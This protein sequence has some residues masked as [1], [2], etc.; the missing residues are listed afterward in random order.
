[1]TV[2]H[3]NWWKCWNCTDTFQLQAASRTECALAP[4]YSVHASTFILG[5]RPHTNRTIVHPDKDFTVHQPLKQ[6]R[7]RKW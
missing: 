2:G 4:V 1:M 7:S 3:S 6:L 5:I